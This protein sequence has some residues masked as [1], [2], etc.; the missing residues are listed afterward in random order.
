MQAQPCK[1]WETGIRH[2]YEHSSW[3]AQ[4]D[5]AAVREAPLARFYRTPLELG[6]LSMAHQN[7]LTTCEALMRSCSWS[8]SGACST[9]RSVPG[10]LRTC[11][12]GERAERAQLSAYAKSICMRVRNEC[13]RLSA[14]CATQPNMPHIQSVPMSSR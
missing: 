12:R 1:R 3:R 13:A 5:F 7:S 10:T 9:K 2:R 11:Q 14:S 4:R 6:M 8:W